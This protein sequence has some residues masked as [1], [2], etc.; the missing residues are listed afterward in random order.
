MSELYDLIS[1]DVARKYPSLMKDIE[2][3]IYDVAPRIL[4]S[5]DPALSDYTT[6]L[7]T[8]RGIKICTGKAVTEVH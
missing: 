4:P 2:I 8:E 7:F 5:F 1:D 3:S 6:K